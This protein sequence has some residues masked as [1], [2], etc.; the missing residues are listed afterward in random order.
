MA[1]RSVTRQTPKLDFRASFEPSTVDVEKRTVD[2]IW[3][4]GARVLRGYWEP[5]LEELSLDPKHVRM[6]RLQSG[7]AP[8]LNSHGSYDISQVLGVVES[9]RLEKSKGTATV[10]FD[11]GP[12]GE[13]AFRR[14]REGTLRNVSVGYTTYKMQ[15]VEDGATTTPV[16]RAIDWEPAELSLVPIGADAGSVV[17][18]AG[19]LNPCEFIEER[20]MP[21]PEV[22]T[23]PAPIPTP[24]PA[25]PT[26]I[27][28]LERAATER[29]LG[30]QRVGRAL[31]RPQTEVDAAIQNGLTLEEFRAA[32]VEALASAPADKGGTIPFVPSASISAGADERDKYQRCAEAAIFLRA[33]TSK[34]VA[35][36]EAKR[37]QKIDLDPGPC[38]FMSLR[39]LARDCLERAGHSTRGMSPDQLVGLAFTARAGNTTSDFPIVLEN[40][41]NKT[42]LSAYG[43]TPDT[44]REWCA[45]GTLTDFRPHNRYRPGSLGVLDA[46]PEG[47][48]YKNATIPDSEK[49]SITGA[50]KGRI[51]AISRQM[52]INDDMG[53][54]NDVATRLGRAAALT[55]E[56][57]AYAALLANPVMGDGLALFHATHGNIGAGGAAISVATIDADRVLMASQQDPAK[58]EYIDARPAVLLVPVGLG[59]QARV[60]NQAQYDTDKVANARNQEPNKVVGLYRKVIDTPRLT[61]TTRYS[62]AD[63]SIYPVME[64]AFLNG[65]Q[66]PYLE[67]MQTW[68]VDGAEFKLRIDYGI[69]PRDWRGVVR[70][71]GV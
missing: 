55:I 24:A 42:A 65:V 44:W 15:K 11:S 58:N 64:V 2:L 4:T 34:M 16:Y 56:V 28:A 71:P 19:G 39:E 46:L 52:I 37:G 50:T 61:G 18:S 30:I 29:V 53:A 66:E 10:R 3:T 47:A 22:P 38:R 45:T 60:I 48:E 54:F 36:G 20:D 7:A 43:L 41:L 31:S 63:P 67:T 12:E 17:R 68:R 35:E 57:D 1:Q 70:N 40:A 23:T 59:G 14:V 33:G 32:A 5:Y 26:D 51:I 8:L 13:D 6:E 49:Q 62:F 27:R 69:A 21:T 25:A 9:A